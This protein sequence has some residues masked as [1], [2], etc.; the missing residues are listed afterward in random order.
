MDFIL[1][2][3]LSESFE[4]ILKLIL[5][6]ILGILI[7]A[8]REHKRKAA[9]LRTYMLVSLGSALFTVLSS[10]VGAG[11]LGSIVDPT[12]IAAQI[13]VGIGFIGAGLI[14]L[15]DDRLEGLTTAAG[16]WVTAAIGMAVGFGF[17]TAAI[18][19]T[20]MVLFAFWVL[21]LLDKQIHDVSEDRK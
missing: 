6:A 17:Y 12:R 14:I 21:T 18:F 16:L 13:V 19:S 9:G 2:F 7:G 5:A 20:L 10:H 3:V 15:R 11:A 4:I 1:G 8:E